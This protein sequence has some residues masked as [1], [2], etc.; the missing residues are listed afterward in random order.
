MDRSCLYNR[1][2]MSTEGRCEICSA[3]LT[4]VPTASRSPGVD[5]VGRGPLAGPVV[6]GAVILDPAR[7]IKGLRDSKELTPGQREE[8]AAVIRDCAAAWA[9]GRAEVVEI[10]RINILRATLVAMRRAVDALAA[11]VRLAYIDGN[12]A[13]SIDGCATVTVVGGDAK[14][15]AISAA[16]IIAKVARDAEMVAAR[17]ALPGL[18]IRVSQGLCNGRASRGTQEAG[19]DAAAPAVLCAGG[20][21][22]RAADIVLV[23]YL[24]TRDLGGGGPVPARWAR[25]RRGRVSPVP[26]GLFRPVGLAAVGDGLVPSR[27]VGQWA[28]VRKATH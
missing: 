16:S 22:R 12:M 28:K 3:N 25:H 27:P 2:Q 5:E 1:D 19:T 8:L 7:E 14:V 4:R 15:P 17:G 13:P 20:R 10:D 11:D 9:L 21:C 6:A 23:E 24:R 26:S 18:W